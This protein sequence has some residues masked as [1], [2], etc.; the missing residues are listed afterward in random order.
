VAHACRE[1]ITERLA[2]MRYYEVVYK[3][4]VWH[5]AAWRCCHNRQFGRRCSVWTTI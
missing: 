4:E 3:K 1:I 2:I 5:T